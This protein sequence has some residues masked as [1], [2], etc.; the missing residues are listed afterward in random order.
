MTSLSVSA[1]IVPLLQ[2]V[3]YK[4]YLLGPS[5]Q[6]SDIV[7]EIL[8]ASSLALIGAVI[9]LPSG[10]ALALAVTAVMSTTIVG[11]AIATSLL[12]PV[13]SCGI[14]GSRALSYLGR[15]MHAEMH[16]RL[17][18]RP[19]LFEQASIDVAVERAK[20]E[21]H[22]KFDATLRKHGVGT[23]ALADRLDP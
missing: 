5:F 12:P 21:A 6:K 10:A 1:A 14:N 17:D 22:D 2:S 9:A 3:S 20:A 8:P 4:G 16:A 23:Q 15:S 18:A 7:L 13:I 11:V 19:F